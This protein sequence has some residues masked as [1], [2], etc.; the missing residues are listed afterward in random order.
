MKICDIVFRPLLKEQLM[1][2]LNQIGSN[3]GDF[4]DAVFHPS[5]TNLPA[6]FLALVFAVLLVVAMP[7]GARQKMRLAG[8]NRGRIDRQP[9]PDLAGDLGH[10][11]L[12]PPRPLPG[13]RVFSVPRF[14]G[15]SSQ[16]HIN[17]VGE[18]AAR[19]S[20]RH[21]ERQVAEG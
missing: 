12:N 19:P 11:A 14:L 15:A 5:A 2:S 18:P 16:P 6:G 17:S 4:I 21:N 9:N 10:P 7:E 1:Y 20:D 13:G 8:L 3:L